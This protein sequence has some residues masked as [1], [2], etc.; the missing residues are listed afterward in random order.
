MF[1]VGDQVD[2]VLVGDLDL[3]GA[4]DVSEIVDVD[5]GVGVSSSAGEDVDV[6]V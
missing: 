5:I 6:I 4:G 2:V 3:C 1:D